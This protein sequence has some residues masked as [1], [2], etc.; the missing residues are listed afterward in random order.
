MLGKKRAKRS[1]RALQTVVLLSLSWK[2]KAAAALWRVIW[3]APLGGV[4]LWSIFVSTPPISMNPAGDPLLCSHID[5]SWISTDF[6]LRGQADKVH[7]NCGASWSDICVHTC[8]SSRDRTVS[9]WRWKCWAPSTWLLMF[10][11]SSPQIY[12]FPNTINF[13]LLLVL[14]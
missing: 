6:M 11:L 1:D 7:R 3:S 4:T 2:H 12:F 8:I 13:E 9:I 14:I 10:S 5:F